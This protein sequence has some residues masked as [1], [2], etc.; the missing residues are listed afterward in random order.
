MRLLTVKRKLCHIFVPLVFF[1]ENAFDG[2]NFNK[3]LTSA[4][5]NPE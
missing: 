4:A 5:N 1:M 2:W 3:N